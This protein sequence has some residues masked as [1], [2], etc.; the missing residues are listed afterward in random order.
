MNK[1][2]LT[3]KTS[4]IYFQTGARLLI[5]PFF[6]DVLK[7]EFYGNLKRKEKNRTIINVIFFAAT[8]GT[9][10]TFEDRHRVV[11][12][13]NGTTLVFSYFNINVV[14]TRCS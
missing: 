14:N 11:E 1:Y 5:L 3:S 2:T 9:K 8:N 12:I 10:S 4:K 13:Q 7:V 6:T